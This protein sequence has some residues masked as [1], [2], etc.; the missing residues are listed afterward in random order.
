MRA[1]RFI[2]MSIILGGLFSGVKFFPLSWAAKLVTGDSFAYE[3]SAQGTVWHGYISADDPTFPVMETRVS[4]KALMSGMP[5]TLKTI[6][7]DI[8]A[9]AKVGRYA[10]TNGSLVYPLH[11]AQNYDPRFAGLSGYLR[12]TDMAA[13]FA[14]DYSGCL[15]ATGSV[16]TNII[17]AIS[18]KMGIEDFLKGAP[19]LS[20]PLSCEDGKLLAKL[21][22]QMDDYVLEAQFTVSIDGRYI[23]NIKVSPSASEIAAL[24]PLYGFESRG[25]QYVLKEQGRWK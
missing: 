16:E 10:F 21:T 7:S 24:I 25:G 9:Q 8:N 19:L 3:I 4:P 12:V 22:A 1:R 6:G 2:T 5:V 13:S 23:A 14:K 17:Q 15:E 18:T 11:R 20:G